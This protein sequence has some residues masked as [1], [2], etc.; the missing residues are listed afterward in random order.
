M[1]GERTTLATALVL[2]PAMASSFP[3]RG[4]GPRARRL[5]LNGGA[6][7]SHPLPGSA[8]PI[9][10]LEHA[11]ETVLA[12]QDGFGASGPDEA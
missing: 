6:R 12:V 3:R 5:Q 1:L 10:M 7:P 9:V 2:L 11:D 8:M 4:L